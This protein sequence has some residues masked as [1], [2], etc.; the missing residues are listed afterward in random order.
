MEV[1]AQ[2]KSVRISTRK[3]RLVADP[4]RNMSAKDAMN[5]LVLTKKH[6][7][8]V[9]LKTIKSAMANAANN[10]KLVSDNLIIAKLIVNE[11]PFL[12]RF[13]PSTRGRV[14][15][16]KKRSSHITVVLKEK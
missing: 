10:H 14:H 9:L 7:A 5:T 12:K 3:V 15:P 1:T 8:D 6:G 13:R 4:I 16:Y 2:A 11:G